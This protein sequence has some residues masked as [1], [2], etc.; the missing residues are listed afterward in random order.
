[1]KYGAWA[2]LSLCF[3]VT[4][5][6][7]FGNTSSTAAQS[8]ASAGST[9]VLT[10]GQGFASTAKTLSDESKAHAIAFLERMPLSFEANQ[11]QTDPRV[12]FL[13]HGQGYTLFLTRRGEAV[14]TTRDARQSL[15]PVIDRVHARHYC[16]QDLRGADVARRFL[17]PD[18]LLSRLER[19]PQRGLPVGGA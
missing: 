15:W 17:A 4:G 1:M 2:R 18:V 7:L 14:H 11:G 13:A 19:H 16:Q 12:K 3:L 5:T 6:F 8:L 9:T 10:R